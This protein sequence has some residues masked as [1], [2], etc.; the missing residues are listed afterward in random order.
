MSLTQEQAEELK[1]QLREQVQTMP[2][3]R[4]K[5]ALI[6]IDSMSSEALELM[7]EQQQQRME[8]GE[9]SK[10][11]FRMIVDKEIESNIVEET[12]DLL[13]VLD[14]N[15]ISK[16][17]IMIIPKKAVS[18]EKALLEQSLPLAKSLSDRVIEG[19]KAKKTEIQAEKKF[20]EA[21]V[22]IIPIYDSPLTLASPRQS[23]SPEELKKIVESLQPQPKKE[24]IKI[25]SSEEKPRQTLKLSRRIP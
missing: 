23:S 24:V 16:G 15:P 12:S 9:S 3:E 22:H 19:L 8:K 10:T 21:V 20:G 17:H 13:A 4:K 5:Q 6:Q 7:L 18:E 11:I 14:I 2:E 1:K 25:S